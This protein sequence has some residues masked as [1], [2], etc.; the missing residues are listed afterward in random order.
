METPALAAEI[1]ELGAKAEPKT[2]PPAAVIN[3]PQTDNGRFL[4]FFSISLS[5]AFLS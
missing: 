5:L 2:A 4:V 1:I 3:F